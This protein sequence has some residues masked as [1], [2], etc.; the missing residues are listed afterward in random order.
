[1]KIGKRL[2]I[3]KIEKFDELKILHQIKNFYKRIEIRIK[4]KIG[5][6]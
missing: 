1:M 6:N 4:W 3:R 5:P 2:K